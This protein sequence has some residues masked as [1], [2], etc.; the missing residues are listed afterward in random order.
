[1]TD[2]DLLFLPWVRRGAAA[3]LLQPDTFGPD[4]PGVASTTASLGLNAGAPVTVPVTVMG[5]GHVTSLD[6]RQVVRTDPAPGSRTFEP[7]YFP[8][9]ELDEPS[10]PWLFTPAAP[11][12]QDRLRPWLCLVVV[13]AQ[14]GV[15]L[16]PPVPGGLPV[17][18]ISRPASPAAELPDPADSWA[19][20]HASVTTAAAGAE[21]ELLAELAAHPERSVARLLCPRVLAPDTDYLACLVPTFELGRKAGLGLPVSPDDERKLDPAW[22]LGADAVE[23]PV[24]H[25]WSFATG[26]GGDFQSLALLLRARPLPPGVSVRPV[27]VSE[28]GLPVAVPAG[29]TLPVA[30]ALRPV[31][32][33]AGGWPPIPG[34]QAAWET[35]LAAVLDAPAT[36]PASGDPLLA[37]PLYGAAQAGRNTLDPGRPDRWFERLNLS[38]THRAVA[39]LGARVV[40][41]HQDALM[42]SAWEQAAD[43]ARANQLLRQA[44][45]GCLVATSL[46]RRH[47]ARMDPAVGLQVLAPARRRMTRTPAGAALAL[48]LD[49]TGLPGSAYATALRRLARPRGPIGRRLRR[50]DA[51]PAPPAGTGG[52]LL[53]LQ[54]AAVLS[55]RRPPPTRRVGLETVAA[56]LTPPA[57]VGWGEAT[58]EA[59][60]AAPLR[61]FF[62]IVPMGSP[63]PVRPPPPAP[64]PPVLLPKQ[65][66]EPPEPPEPH[67][68]PHPHPHP[69]PLRLP[70]GRRRSRHRSNGHRRPGNLRSTPRPQRETRH[71]PPRQTPPSRPWL[72][73]RRGQRHPPGP[74]SRP[75]LRA[76]SRGDDQRHPAR[77]DRGRRRPRGRQREGPRPRRRAARPAVGTPRRLLRHR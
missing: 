36:V 72:P 27:D 6:R 50:V 19:W 3:A 70:R 10:L 33:V 4:Q 12:A 54:P 17:L 26:A 32:A 18:R 28:S 61:P 38:P 67:P 35:A 56:S 53:A 16:D 20:A 2:A 8:L 49:D 47:L 40:Q 75:Q 31:G 13:R 25:H 23:L 76:A 5:P 66:P 77:P 39:H 15:R 58:A 1:M 44:E 21:P 7:N 73:H 41:H 37:P 63:V 11:G 45:L 24:Y 9:V 48:A 42:A 51:S 62:A 69:P 46:H 68:H 65:P 43:L 14:D 52:V 22:S 57:D 29:T 30:G 59:V 60:A 74:H 55:R 64:P 71:R 34:L